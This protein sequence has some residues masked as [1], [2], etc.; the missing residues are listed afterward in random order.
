MLLILVAA[1]AFDSALQISL[2]VL[3]AKHRLQDAALATWA[4][5]VV[6]I[7]ATWFLLPPLGLEGAGIGWGLGKVVGVVLAV[8]FLFRGGFVRAQKSRMV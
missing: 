8:A 2:A 4:T 7:G 5:L 6:A 3:R 1:A